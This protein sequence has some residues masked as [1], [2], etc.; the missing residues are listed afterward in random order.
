[1]Y[2]ITHQLLEIMNLASRE[3]HFGMY[4]LTIVFVSILL[5][6]FGIFAQN[7]FATNYAISDKL[8]CEDSSIE[9]VWHGL[10]RTCHI[11]GF[12]LNSGDSLT[13][14]S[15][16]G[17][18]TTGTLSNHG[19]INNHGTIYN[20]GKIYNYG[21]IA[22]NGIIDNSG[23]LFNQCEGI[24][25]NNG[26]FSGNLIVEL[27]VDADEDGIVDQLDTQPN[28]FSNDFSD[29]GRNGTITGTITSRGDQKLT[30]SE[31]PD[32]DDVIDTITINRYN[33]LTGIAFA[34]INGKLYV[35]NFD[36]GE[37]YV[38]DS[39]KNRITNTISVGSGNTAGIVYVP[40]N[41]N[42]YVTDG[43]SDT[44]FVIDA[45]YNKVIDR[46]S[47]GDYP[48]SIGF[49]SSSG[50]VY[51]ST[52]NST[53]NT[54]TV[55]V[56]DTKSNKVIDTITDV[57][58]GSSGLRLVS[59]NGRLYV[60]DY[61]LEAVS[62]VDTQTNRVI[63]TIDGITEPIGMAISSNSN[64]YV[65]SGNTGTVSV[66]DTVTNQ[67][68]DTIPVGN[69]AFDLLFLSGKI[70]A[71]TGDGVFVIDTSTN[72]VIDKITVNSFHSS[73]A[74]AFAPSSG[75]LYVTDVNK[76][77][78]DVIR[79]MP[80][81][82]V[83]KISADLSGGPEPAIVSVCGGTLS[84]NAGD[85]IIVEC[86]SIIA[87]V[88]AGQVEV[89]YVDDSNN[90]ANMVLDVGVDITFEP[91]TFTWKTTSGITHITIL[92]SNEMTANLSLPADNEIQY[93][94]STFTL[95]APILNNEI[96]IAIIDDRQ[97]SIN[98]GQ[99]VSLSSSSSL[100]VNSAD[101]AG[102]EFDGMWIELW[103]DGEIIQEGQ[104]PFSAEI[105]SGADYEIFM[106]SWENITFDHWDDNTTDAR[107]TFN[108][109][110][111]ATFTAFF[112]TNNPPGAG[113]DSV[114]T[115]INQPITIDVLANDSD[116][117]DDPLTVDSITIAPEHGAVTIN[118]DGTITYTPDFAFIGS[119]SFDY[120]ISDDNRGT[121]TAMVSVTVDAVVIPPLPIHLLS[122][123]P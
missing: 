65:S 28:A 8:S 94:P 17:L 89:G 5:S 122:I 85:Q 77:S 19:M 121:D 57:G 100:L 12:S 91:Q 61:N 87:E 56:I 32:P 78:V 58:Y 110:E 47:I 13:I 106:D 66:I 18:D 74:M 26:T 69:A 11:F 40:S 9:G 108:I 92:T 38:I 31:E 21:N 6:I 39:I 35:T 119:D 23:A 63:G 27:C 72:E 7:V 51:V 107:R 22:N 3:N 54:G 25:T 93:D 43:L 99:T 1:M 105:Q 60:P 98:P 64:L 34:P 80:V 29:V 16:I 114:E 71:P 82:Y 115:T 116:Q 104:T 68:I 102:T 46:I 41:G 37:I 67:V 97:F 36:N 33:A 81:N 53:A 14:I 84:F 75:N 42:L 48:Q 109:S 59:A 95:S 70:Y 49:D 76:G 62:V 73:Y 4:L 55:F 24:V 120:Q 45:K 88:I 118:S 103:Q 96:I 15:G 113:D 83:A 79:T 112:N 101:L 50:N 117:D 10:T 90:S 111:D 86:G 30:I 44:V 2:A 123:L 52:T 20:H